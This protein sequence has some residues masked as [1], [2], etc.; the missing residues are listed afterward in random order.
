MSRIS[1]PEKA[2]LF[3]V[4]LRSKASING[5]SGLAE[6]VALTCDRM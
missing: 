6:N 5:M 1:S 2:G 3:P 4:K